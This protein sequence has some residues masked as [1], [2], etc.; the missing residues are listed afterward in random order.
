MNNVMKN[1]DNYIVVT[2]GVLGVIG[3]AIIIPKTAI[4]FAER[5]TSTETVAK[6]VLRLINLPQAERT[7]PNSNRY[8][9]L[10]INQFPNFFNM[11]YTILNHIGSKRR[12]SYS[13]IIAGGL[14]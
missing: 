3:S 9:A 10:V 11:I 13:K 7:I 8:S 4:S 12:T 5:T 6:S 14:S 2:A 1:I